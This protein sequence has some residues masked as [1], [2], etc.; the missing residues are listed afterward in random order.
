MSIQLPRAT[1]EPLVII[2]WTYKSPAEVLYYD[3]KG[4]EK[5]STSFYKQGNSIT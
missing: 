2:L 3:K 5:S 1:A 4:K